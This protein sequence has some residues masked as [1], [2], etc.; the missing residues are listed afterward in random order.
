L[1][2]KFAAREVIDALGETGEAAAGCLFAFRRRA[3]SVV[4]YLGVNLF[5]NLSH[6]DLAVC[7]AAVADD[8]GCSLAYGPSQNRI[9]VAGQCT[10]VTVYRAGDVGC[11]QDLARAGECLVEGGLAVGSDRLT[12][13]AQRSTRHALDVAYLRSGFVRGGR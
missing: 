13:F 12:N 11:L 5:T 10:Y 1:R 7:G 8:V 6:P 2:R 3:E 4:T 9:H